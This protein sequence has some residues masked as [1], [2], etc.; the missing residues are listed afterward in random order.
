M[1]LEQ[2]LSINGPWMLCGALLFMMWDAW[3][4]QD[5][6]AAEAIRAVNEALRAISTDVRENGVTIQGLRN[7]MARQARRRE[8]K[9]GGG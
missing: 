2:W 5:R 4:R 3:R 1:G 9:T 7:E 8:A 6:G